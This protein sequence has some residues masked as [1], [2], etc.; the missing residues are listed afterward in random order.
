M[1]Y[2]DLTKRKEY[3]KEYSKQWHTENQEK[4]N[5]KR[6]YQYNE[7]KE[8]LYDILGRECV[9]CGFEDSRALQFDHINGKGG[10]NHRKYGS[11]FNRY[12]AKRPE[13]ALALLQ[14]LCANCNW[15]K[16]VEEYE[17]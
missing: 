17:V 1:P 10:K 7:W 4:Q 12:F 5:N 6:K 3:H 8:R 11:G 15:I 13:L 16:R 2:K 14:V 9:K